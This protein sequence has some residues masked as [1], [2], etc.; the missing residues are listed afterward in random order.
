MNAADVLAARALIEQRGF[1]V[2][3]REQ[4][5]ARLPEA[6]E[7]VAPLSVVAVIVKHECEPGA[8]HA[9]HDPDAWRAERLRLF[10]QRRTGQ[11]EAQPEPAP[12]S[13]ATDVQSVAHEH[14][15]TPAAFTRPALPDLQ[16]VAPLTLDDLTARARYGQPV[17]TGIEVAQTLASFVDISTD[18]QALAGSMGLTVV[19]SHR[20]VEC[21]RGDVL[22]FTCT[23]PAEVE[24]VILMLKHGEMKRQIA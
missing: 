19:A 24:H 9:D 5:A 16:E 7:V 12:L 8:P 2:F 3:T 4:T 11:T 14:R 17:P 23:S 10:E 15:E 1:Y 21:R 18:L 6:I 20:G 13:A 22:E